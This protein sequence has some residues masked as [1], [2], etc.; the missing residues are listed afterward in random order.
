MN[1][2]LFATQLMILQGQPIN[3]NNN[4]NNNN[5]KVINKKEMMDVTVTIIVTTGLIGGYPHM[6]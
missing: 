4:N 1:E 2:F 6:S 3:N 5:N